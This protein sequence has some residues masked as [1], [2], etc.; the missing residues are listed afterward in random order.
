[1][2]SRF[3][4]LTLLG[5]FLV[6]VMIPGEAGAAEN[7]EI[8][9]QNQYLS[10]SAVELNSHLRKLWIDHVIWT[11]NYIVS[12]V[13]GMEDQE[14]VLARLLQNQQ[15]LGN[16]IKPY[17]GEAAGN[18]LAELLKEHILIAGKIVGAAKSGNQGDV[19]KYNKE[20]YRNADD[21]ARFLSSANPNWSMKE[22]REQ[23]HV[24]LQLVTDAVVARIG[25]D[26]VADIHAF[27]KGEQ[28]MIKLADTLTAGII[29]Q[30]P[31][32][33]K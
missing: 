4:K 30:F 23:L 21:I 8:H 25:K 2:N 31:K 17:Y 6:S 26:W 33:F 13:A 1:M 5:M 7:K 22:L 14:K 12:A 16:A 15:D 19:E 29:K 10:Q 24:H 32:S 11:R 18:K 28:H 20:W 9:S 3:L 27:D